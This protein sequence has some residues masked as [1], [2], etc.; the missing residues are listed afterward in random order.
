[1]AKSKG[2]GKPV[3]EIKSAGRQNGKAPKKRPKV[4]DPEKR[5]LV[6]KV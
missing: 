4:W 6:T 3:P 2:G 1:M 5:R